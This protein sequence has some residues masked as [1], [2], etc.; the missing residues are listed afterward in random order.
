MTTDSEVKQK[1]LLLEKHRGISRLDQESKRTHG[2]YSRVT[3]ER[4]TIAK[5]FSDKKH[6]GRY[7]SLILALEWRDQTTILLGKS[8]NT[9]GLSRVRSTPTGVVGVRLDETRQ[10]YRVT[11]VKDGKQGKTTVSILKHGK[12]KAFEIACRIRQE[13]IK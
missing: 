12:V 9:T 5:F 3:H 10:C 6:G 7:S 4:R 13:K 8:L 1:K 2:W 11:W